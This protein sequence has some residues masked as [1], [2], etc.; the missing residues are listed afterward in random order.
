[1]AQ[2]V[3]VLSA[4]M[5]SPAFL[6]AVAVNE[7]GNGDTTENVEQLFVNIHKLVGEAAVAA[8][9]A[10]IRNERSLEDFEDLEDTDLLGWFGQTKTSGTSSGAP[11]QFR[12]AQSLHNLVEKVL[13][14]ISLLNQLVHRNEL[15]AM[16]LSQNG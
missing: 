16:G 4:P 6:L 1:M 9:E 10:T 2:T 11:H 13:G 8:E 7:I 5:T 14:N 15:L 3:Q 12:P